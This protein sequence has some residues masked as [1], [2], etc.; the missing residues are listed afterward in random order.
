MR[1]AGIMTNGPSFLVL[2]P[3]VVS[4]TTV[5][6]AGTLSDVYIALLKV[7][8]SMEPRFLGT[9]FPVPFGLLKDSVS[10]GLQRF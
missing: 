5:R 3:V 10:F 7:A 4:F 6:F 1:P 8:V 2:L 9:L